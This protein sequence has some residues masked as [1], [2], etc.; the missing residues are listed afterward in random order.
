MEG[1][2]GACG[3]VDDGRWQRERR[4]LRDGGVLRRL[5]RLAKG[6]TTFETRERCIRVMMA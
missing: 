6:M 1:A 4:E 3:D 2:D 5:V